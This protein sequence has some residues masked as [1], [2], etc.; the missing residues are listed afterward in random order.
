[1]TT[2]AHLSQIINQFIFVLVSN[3]APKRG[4]FDCFLSKYAYL[5]SLKKG[6]N[7]HI[8]GTWLE[9]GMVG[10]ESAGH[11]QGFLCALMGADVWFLVAG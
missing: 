6:S 5:H 8:L 1:M 7:N 11:S 2:V 9:W 3:H 10:A 4:L